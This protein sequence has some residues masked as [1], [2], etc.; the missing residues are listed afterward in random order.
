M[1]LLFPQRFLLHRKAWVPRYV[2][3]VFVAYMT[4]FA[5]LKAGERK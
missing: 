4:S 5:L 2:D 3:Y 1:G